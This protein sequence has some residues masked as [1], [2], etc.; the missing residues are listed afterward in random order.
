[1]SGNVERKVVPKT[2]DFTQAGERYRSLSKLEK[3]HL[4][5]NIAVELWKCKPD[6]ISRVLQ[7]FENADADF[8]ASVK[9]EMELYRKME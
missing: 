2:D 6:I 5:D 3:S 4:S 7:Y 9:Q 8:A 1:L